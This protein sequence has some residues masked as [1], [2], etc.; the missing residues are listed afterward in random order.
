MLFCALMDGS[1]SMD[2]SHANMMMSWGETCSI[3]VLFDGGK[4][5]KRANCAGV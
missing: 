4:C 2:G 5:N 3:T 1:L